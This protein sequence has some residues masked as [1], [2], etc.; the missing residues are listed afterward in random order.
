MLCAADATLFV[1]AF[2]RFPVGTELLLKLVAYNRVTGL[3]RAALSVKPR[4]DAE[5]IAIPVG[6]RV[7]GEISYYRADTDTVGITIADG[8]VG[9]IQ[10]RGIEATVAKGDYVEA[11]T[12]A[13]PS[14]ISGNGIY[15]VPLGLLQHIPAPTGSDAIV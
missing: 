15:F 4:P 2:T 10:L 9:R 12:L 7:S 11:E 5:S 8:L 1:N 13:V 6:T 14:P 3:Y